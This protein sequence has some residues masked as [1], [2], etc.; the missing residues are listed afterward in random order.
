M[1][2]FQYL[3]TKR[4]YF[5]RFFFLSNAGLL[6]ILAETKDPKKVQPYLKKC[7]NGID[8]ME[9]NSSNEVTTLKSFIV[10]IAS[11][12]Y[13]LY[14]LPKLH[15][16]LIMTSDKIGRRNRTHKMCTNRCSQRTSRK[17]AF[18]ARAFN[19]GYNFSEYKESL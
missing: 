4:L 12:F 15:A 1:I 14:S 8:S 18:G 3:E 7:F 5:P 13:I 6:Q 19:E 2:T 9:F 10:W 11:T 16:S 17:M